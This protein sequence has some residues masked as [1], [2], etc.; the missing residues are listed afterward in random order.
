MDLIKMIEMNI[1]EDAEK[2]LDQQ[3]A[4]SN[5]IKN[6]E[7]YKNHCKSIS[8]IIR[9]TVKSIKEK[10]PEAKIDST[11]MQ[12]AGL[13]H[14]IGNCI[15]DNT[16]HHPIIGADFLKSLGLERIAKIIRTHN[17]IK[18]VVEKTKFRNIDPDDLDVETWNEALITH[19]S[20]CCGKNEIITF[21]EKFKRMYE[22]RDDFFK[23]VATKGEKRLREIYNDVERL[24]AGDKSV[25]DKHKFL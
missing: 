16:L 9:D 8:K 1:V 6:P 3:I 20:M 22:K 10:N 21:D 25:M 18:E 11:E 7:A 17:F 23:E 19:A 12:I 24:K 14:D 2:F 4:K 5:T 15:S 13:L